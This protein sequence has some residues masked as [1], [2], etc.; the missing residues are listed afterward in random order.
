MRH[1]VLVPFINL[2]SGEYKLPGSFYTS[3]DYERVNEL[4]DLGFIRKNKDS[5]NLKKPSTAK[6]AVAKDADK[7]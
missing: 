7:G 2:E 4:H 6:K 5:E 1:S 3:E